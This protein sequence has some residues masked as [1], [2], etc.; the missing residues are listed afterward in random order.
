MTSEEVLPRETAAGEITPALADTEPDPIEE[1][2]PR[3]RRP[4]PLTSIAFGLAVVLLIAQGVA[5]FLASTGEPR[6]A[7][8]LAEI[9]IILTAVPFVIGIVALVRGPHR[10]WAIA[11]MIVSVIANP[12][13]LL[14]VLSYFESL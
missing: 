3:P 12:F 5:V 1:R 9:L 10:L 4:W 8:V 11:A 14:H 6:A 13:I 7:S 2:A